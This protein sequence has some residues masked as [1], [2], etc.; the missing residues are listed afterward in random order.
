MVS[1]SLNSLS[2]VRL[3]EWNRKKNISTINELFFIVSA[4]IFPMFVCMFEAVSYNIYRCH[5]TLHVENGKSNWRVF[6]LTLIILCAKWIEFSQTTNANFHCENIQSC[7]GRERRSQKKK[8]NWTNWQ[9]TRTKN[10]NRFL[11]LQCILL[12]FSMNES[13]Y[14]IIRNTYRMCT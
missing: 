7:K 5:S 13:N 11:Y 1:H 10:E 3:R 14:L 2:T 9:K 12:R 4:C 8:K 6:R